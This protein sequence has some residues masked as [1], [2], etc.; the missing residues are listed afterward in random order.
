M[1]LFFLRLPINASLHQTQALLV[2]VLRYITYDVLQGILKMGYIILTYIII[3]KD[4]LGNVVNW[5]K[6]E[7]EALPWLVDYFIVLTFISYFT[8]VVLYKFYYYYVIYDI[9][10]YLWEI[11]NVSFL[12]CVTR[13]AVNVY[14]IFII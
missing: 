7:F 6:K 14:K 11:Q 2:N 8:I 12:C 5:N 3:I 4:Q 10:H 1:L 9:L 13:W